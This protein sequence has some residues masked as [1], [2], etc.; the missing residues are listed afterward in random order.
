MKVS[1][2]RIGNSRGIRLN[3]M[4]L[5]KYKIEDEVE[6][7]LEPDSILIR[8]IVKPRQDWDKA[9]AEMRKKEDDALLI[10]SVLDA[11]DWD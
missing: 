2:I 8:P 10:D 3:K 5:E 6:L 4:L 11:N 1:I 9:F 7:V